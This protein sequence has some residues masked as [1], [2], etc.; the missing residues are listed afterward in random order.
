MIAKEPD[1]KPSHDRLL[2]AG[3]EA[4]RQMHFYLNRA[5]GH[6]DEV[7]VFADLRF[8]AEKD[9]CQIDHLDLDMRDIREIGLDG[10]AVAWLD[11]SGRNEMHR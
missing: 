5:F 1:K 8:P 6:E 10:F 9:S 11:G 3:L 4:E 2:A 7:M